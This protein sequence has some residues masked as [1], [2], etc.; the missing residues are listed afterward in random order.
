MKRLLSMILVTMMLLGLS[1]IPSIAEEQV[2]L[3]V[4]Y[5]D[6]SFQDA[7]QELAESFTAQYPN[8]QIEMTQMPFAQYWTKLQTT[9]TTDSAPDVFWMNYNYATAFIPDKLLLDITQDVMDPSKFPDTCV[10]MFVEDG[11]MYGVPFLYDTIA[12]FYNKQLFDAA[13]VPYPT[14]DWTWEDL[15]DAAKK[16]TI[17]DDQGNVTQYGFIMDLAAQAGMFN[18]LLQNGVTV[19]EEDRVAT[20]FE[21]EEAYEAFQLIYDMMYVDGTVPTAADLSELAKDDRFMA[22]QG[23]MVYAVPPR[24]AR[25][26]EAM[27]E[28]V[29]DV[30]ELPAGAMEGCTLNTCAFSAS[31]K[32]AHPEEA[33][34][35]LSYVASYEGQS[36]LSQAGLVPYEDCWKLWAEQFPE[37]NLEAFINQIDTATIIPTSAYNPA[38]TRKILETAFANIFSQS[39]G[40]QEGLAQAADEI[41]QVMEK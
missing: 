39:V 23:A 6:T 28:G 7:M 15:R 24:V 1:V 19:F 34:L 12:M 36:I 31:A 3:N 18:F 16:L 32:T 25:Y 2:T 11:K 17:K 27:G 37:M 41:A 9:L 8:I 14:S 4:F 38:E 10:E 21:C 20:N 35:F 26:T 22:F 40:I 13:G 29:L 33:K 5:W 30:V